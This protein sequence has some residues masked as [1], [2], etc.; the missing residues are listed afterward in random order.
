MFWCNGFKSHLF[1][2]YP[3]RNGKDL[4]EPRINYRKET[5][6]K[7]RVS[8]ALFYTYDDLIILGS[9][10]L[11]GS[12]WGFSLGFNI[13]Y[14]YVI[15]YSIETGTTNA[16]INTGM[17]HEISI[18]FNFNKNYYANYDPEEPRSSF[19]FKKKQ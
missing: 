9:S 4:I 5:D 10:Y 7:S 19:T 3:I 16:I 17:S 8:T 18:R 11:S 6:N 2:F 15:G 1:V 13:N 12:I 14:R